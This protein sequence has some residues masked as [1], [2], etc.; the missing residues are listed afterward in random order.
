VNKLKIIDNIINITRRKEIGTRLLVLFL[1]TSLTPI[2]IT[3]SIIYKRASVR[4]H[5][6]VSAVISTSNLETSTYLG[7]KMRKVISDSV[8][9]SYSDI[10][11][12]LLKN[13]HKYDAVTLYKTN[14]NLLK[15]MSKTYI[16]NDL[17]TEITVYTNNLDK[18]TVYGPYSYRFRPTK[19]EL[20]K[21]IQKCSATNKSVL[22]SVNAENSI[23]LAKK[24]NDTESNKPIGY[25]IMRV[26]QNRISE[27]YQSVYYSP[28]S[29]LLIIDSDGVV[30]S[31]RKSSELA[32]KFSYSD[33]LSNIDFD[34]L[35]SNTQFKTSI[36]NKD[37]IISYSP[38]LGTNWVLVSII[39]STFFTVGS[40][41]LFL[42]LLFVVLICVISAMLISIIVAMSI[43]TPI[44]HIID[45]VNQ[46]KD[47]NNE[48]MIQD[49]GN[50]EVTFMARTFNTMTYRIDRLIN[51]IKQNDKRKRELE[52]QALQE[53]INPHFIANTLNMISEMA[54]EQNVTNIEEISNSLINLIRDCIRPDNELITIEKEISMLS[55]YI[56]IQDYRMFGKYSVSMD[57]DPSILLYK[58][59]HL[60]LQPLVENSIIHG[61]QP[62]RNRRGKILIRGYQEDNMVYFNINDNG[63][64][65]SQSDIE[66]V[67]YNTSENVDKGRFNS[68]GIGNINQRVQLMFGTEYGVVIT[69]TVDVYTS[70]TIK[71]P[72]IN[73]C[74]RAKNV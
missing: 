44:H 73:N 61:I 51:D 14:E 37:Q 7:D 33:V 53:Q 26:D 45:E 4:M 8:Q 25:L 65:M 60:I 20:D 52:I 1:V 22:V 50:D 69:S 23:I 13:Y 71:L 9:I 72:I 48:I 34:N 12:N 42:E 11:Q 18:I 19:S 28:T 15:E 46:Y 39:P 55:S 27:I 43:V 47:D 35:S 49:I 32:K 21:I 54:N 29:R 68:I 31:S 2:I 58:I 70:V 17:I 56:N 24:I 64:G 5:N 66:N 59:P 38:I 74:M 16:Y 62:L 3:G 6:N 57:I 36:S 67:L 10:I 30:V 41:Q 63:I 40:K